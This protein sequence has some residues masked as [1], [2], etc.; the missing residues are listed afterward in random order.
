MDLRL[1]SKKL[2]KF[3]CRSLLRLTCQIF[4][5]T[6]G[7]ELYKYE[8]GRTLDETECMLY[9]MMLST[10]EIFDPEQLSVSKMAHA[11]FDGTCM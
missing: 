6:T 4:E 1:P 7:H 3:T 11:Y 8:P 10:G 5:L 2:D 9:Q